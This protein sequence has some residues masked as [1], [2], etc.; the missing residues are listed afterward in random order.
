MP[1]SGL[2]RS[3]SQGAGCVRVPGALLNQ[4]LAQHFRLVGL[5]WRLKTSS[6][7]TSAAGPGAYLRT[8]LLVSHV[9]SWDLPP[10]PA[11]SY[12]WPTSGWGHC[13]FCY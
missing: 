5:Q 13:L 12:S 6:G 8:I 1:P 7:D 10:S 2:T 9:S 4:G 3:G 11:V